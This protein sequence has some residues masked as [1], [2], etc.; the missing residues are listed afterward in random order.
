MRT[1]KFCPHCGRELRK[2]C[3]KGHAFK[4]NCCDEDFYK[5]EILRKKDLLQVKKLR[6][7]S[8]VPVYNKWWYSA[9]F[10]TMESVSRFRQ[11]N[12]DPEEGYQAFVDAYDKWWEALP[13][14]EKREFY[15]QYK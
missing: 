1:V 6:K 15:K 3:I 7:Q 12:F 13:K 4:C 14:S 2:S 10:D 5:I 9:G 11:S 8:T